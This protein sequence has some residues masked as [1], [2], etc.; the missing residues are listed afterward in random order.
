MALLKVA[1]QR[2]IDDAIFDI[3]LKTGLS[4]PENNLLEIVNAL[5]LD[6]FEAS[7][8]DSTVKGVIE[9]EDKEDSRPNIILNNTLPPEGKTFTLAHELGHFILHKGTK[10]YRID[11]F[12]YSQNT[13]NSLEETQAN[14]FAGSLLVSKDKLL[15]LVSITNDL[16]KI[17]KYFGVSRP[18]IETRIQWLQKNNL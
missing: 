14:Y 12:D 6:V 3:Q 1:K 16:S 11:H 15:N 10:K 13:R 9:Y 4:Y 5:G 18:V 8:A 17:A 2:E 7:M